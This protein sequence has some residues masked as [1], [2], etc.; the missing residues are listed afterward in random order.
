MADRAGPLLRAGDVPGP[1]GNGRRAAP[2]SAFS[3]IRN[4]WRDPPVPGRA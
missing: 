3:R 2:Q 1:C 4:R